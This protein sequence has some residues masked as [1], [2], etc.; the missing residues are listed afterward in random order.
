MGARGR[1]SVTAGVWVVFLGAA[2]FATA[3]PPGNP[4]A[5]DPPTPVVRLQVRVPAA[6]A[7][8]QPLE[9]RLCVE[10]TSRGAAHHVTVRNPVPAHARF[11]R[12]SPEPQV[13]K[14][15]LIW[16][17]GTLEG[18]ACREIV[19]V[20]E[21]TGAGDVKNCARVQIE[22]GQCVTTRVTRPQV[23]L[24]K[25]GP[26]QA[27]VGETITFR[28]VV[29]NTGPV[30]V[31]NLRLTDL[32]D[33]GLESTR[34]KVKN[35]DE[36]TLIPWDIPVLRPGE[37]Y[38]VEHQ[39]VAR[40]EGKLCNVAAVTAA[41]GVLDEAK[42]CV[43]VGKAALLLDMTGPDET[44]VNRPANYTLSVSNPGSLSASN[45]VVTLPLPTGVEFKEAG[46]GGELRDGQ[47]RWLL[48]A[49]PPGERPR[50]LRVRLAAPAA[51]K[52]SFRGTATA[53]AGLTHAAQMTT[54]FGGAGGLTF[55]TEPE[56]NP[57]YVG[58]DTNVVV[59]VLNQGNDTA[60]G[61][62]LTIAVPP[63]LQVV[64]KSAP[65]GVGV[66]SDGGTVTFDKLAELAPGKEARYRV[67]VAPKQA[68]DARIVVKMT[69]DQP[70]LA[71]PVVKETPLT[72]ADPGGG[73][74]LSE[75]RP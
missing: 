3:Q 58:E 26:A 14:D 16:R 9:Y 52:V 49:L 7:P 22:H 31:R 50:A 30:E 73:A 57:A 39:A 43:T 12:A 70:A 64:A 33:A 46:S 44:L 66:T 62:R 18:C 4:C 25:T 8:G 23:K 71:K 69:A 35:P 45:V 15:E 74:T 75:P 11:V 34:E 27:S 51:G 1:S 48:G 32:L 38:P 59:T 54:T 67:Q 28:L 6:V 47:V 60:K 53:D 36:K 13:E 40:K 17:L 42:H 65:E 10:N 2:S 29:T 19:L 56:A 20:L 63:A 72:I 61:V 41:G 24:R 68:G 21:P 5:A 55:V 37:S